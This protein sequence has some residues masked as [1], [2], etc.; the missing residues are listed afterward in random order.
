MDE[1]EKERER[2]AN[3]R[4]WETTNRAELHPMDLTANTI[5]RRIMK[6]P[7]G[8]CVAPKTAKQ[9][10]EEEK[11]GLGESEIDRKR[12]Q[13]MLPKGHYTVTE[14]VTFYTQHLEKKNFYMS[15]ATG[16]NP[17]AKSSGMTQIANDTRAIKNYDGN[18]N[19][20]GAKANVD[21]F[22]KSNALYQPGK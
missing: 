11:I 8:R 22:L 19:F 5:G 20:D 9:K 21:Y 15:A 14:P 18:V 1:T 17:F 6:T 3:T 7:D 4:S 13:E 10:A 2:V 12:L 16:P